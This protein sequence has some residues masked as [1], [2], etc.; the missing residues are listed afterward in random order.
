MGERGDRQSA[1]EN[2]APLDVAVVILTQDEE[3]NVERAVRSVAGRA[4][5][6]F[7]L[8]SGS[9]DRT[10]DLARAAGA[11][12]H[13]NPWPG[14]AAQRNWALDHLPISAG[15]VFFL[16]ADE[17]VDGPF[18]DELAQ[19]IARAGEHVA[20]FAIRRWLAWGNARVAFGGMQDNRILRIVKRG[21]GRCDERVVNEHLVVDGE[22]VDLETLVGHRN[23]SGLGRWVKKH[24]AY[25]PVEAQALWDELWSPTPPAGA[26]ARARLDKRRLYAAL[27]P[28]WRSLARF[29]YVMTFQQGYKDGFG[30]GAY[31]LLHDLAY[32][33][34][35]D[36]HFCAVGARRLAGR[37]RDG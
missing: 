32:N 21:R 13:E 31:H 29:S 1:P 23:E 22:E 7:V 2:D 9:T 11:M 37:P 30:G 18:L 8:D 20:G 14:F 25:A 10:I 12:V 28:F 24:R 34:L 36:V 35:V 16:D 26:L 17:F 3:K 15:W 4:R 6:V 33:V 19:A 27:P 5:E